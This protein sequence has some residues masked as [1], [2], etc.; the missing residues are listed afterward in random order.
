MMNII[1][2]LTYV[3]SG[4]AWVSSYNMTESFKR[5]ATDQI[6]G[7]NNLVAIAILVFLIFS[8]FIRYTRT[9]RRIYAVGS[10]PEAAEVI[11]LPR[12]RILTLVYILNGALAGL[13]GILWVTKFASAQGDTAM[14]YEINV[15]A[16]CVLGGISVSGGR[17][18]VSG[19]I[20]GVILF[21][22]LAN[23]LPLIKVSPFWQQAIQ[24]SVIL[25][26]IITNVLIKQHNDRLALRKRVI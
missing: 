19:L 4:G 13:A 2:G 17:G 23:A 5:I 26:A 1:R 14:G 12:K 10:G 18:K 16:A 8:Y 9:G 11:G 6:F 21:G 20:L 15:I 7:I 22:I 3:V 24:G 25:A